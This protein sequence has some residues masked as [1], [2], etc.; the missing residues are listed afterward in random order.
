[1]KGEWGGGRNVF[2]FFT[3][4]FKSAFLDGNPVLQQNV[5]TVLQLLVVFCWIIGV[6]EHKV[7]ELIILIYCTAILH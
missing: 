5:L 6:S 3:F 7:E 4:V 2:Q 1:L